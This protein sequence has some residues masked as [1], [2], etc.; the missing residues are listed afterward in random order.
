[1]PLAAYAAAATLAISTSGESF[2][3]PAVTVAQGDSVTWTLTEDHNVHINGRVASAFGGTFTAQFPTAGTFSYVCD[4]H[5]GMRGTVQVL[6]RAA[7][8]PAPQPGDVGGGAGPQTPHARVQALKLGRKSLQFATSAPLEGR[9]TILRG[10]GIVRFVRFRVDAGK[11][12]VRYSRPLPVGHYRVVL[13][14][15]DG[16]IEKRWRVR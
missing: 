2:T 12:Y 15:A 8:G 7:P 3:P 11:A 5:S 9:A 13:T 6:A 1:M 4:A 10:R 14:T 16:R